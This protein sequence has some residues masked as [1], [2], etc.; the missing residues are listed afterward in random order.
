MG[1]GCVIKDYDYGY[2]GLLNYSEAINYVS[3]HT[4]PAEISCLKKAGVSFHYE[5][6]GNSIVN[7][8]T[9][10]SDFI[11][12]LSIILCIYLVGFGLRE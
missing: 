9:Y 1:N 2:L 8:V 12:I 6:H 5:M 4:V 10:Y 11:H 3:S 7:E